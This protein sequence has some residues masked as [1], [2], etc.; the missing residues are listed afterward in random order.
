MAKRERVI[1]LESILLD[2]VSFEDFVLQ[3][4]NNRV[5]ILNVCI[6]TLFNF[7]IVLLSP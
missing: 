6:I 1:I 4:T 3:L 2:F 5:D 7:P